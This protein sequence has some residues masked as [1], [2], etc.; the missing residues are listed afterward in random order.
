MDEDGYLYITGRSKDVINRGGEIISPAEVE[1]AV[2]SHPAVE[3]ALAFS[4][5]HDVLQASRARLSE[6]IAH[7]ELPVL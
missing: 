1:D 4:V 3:A 7:P 2:V 5:P 6:A